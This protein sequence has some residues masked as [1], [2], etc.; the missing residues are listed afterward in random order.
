TSAAA[1]QT[2]PEAPQA[3]PTAP[4][5]APVVGETTERDVRVETD[6]VIA[7]FTNRG[8]RLKSWRLKHYLDKQ[9]QPQEL[10]EAE[11]QPLPFTLRTSE[12]AANATLNNALYSVDGAPSSGTSPPASNTPMNLRFEYRDSSGLQAIKEF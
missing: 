9:K 1:S 12:E 5:A 4:A 3:V 6:A 10:I 8:A 2:A 7:V 11:L